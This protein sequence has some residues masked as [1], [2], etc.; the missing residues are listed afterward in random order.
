MKLKRLKWSLKKLLPVL[1]CIP[2]DVD[3]YYESAL[4][5]VTVSTCTVKVIF[6][7]FFLLVT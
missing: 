6:I 1:S 5:V 3:Q 2:S 4:L 7:E